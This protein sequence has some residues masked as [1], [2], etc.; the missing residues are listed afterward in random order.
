MNKLE[1]IERARNRHGYKYNYVDIPNKVTLKDTIN[2]EYKGSIYPQRVSKHL[3]GRCPEKI[4][5][6]KTTDDFISESIEIWGNRFDYSL[7]SY[8]NA[9][10]KIKFI[11]K[12]TGRVFEQLPNNH[13][14]GHI[15][16]SIN[17]EEFINMSKL[18]TDY[19]Y[20]YNKCNYVNKTTKV[21]LVCPL[22]GDF[23]TYPHIHLSQGTFCPYCDDSLGD[24]EIISFLNKYKVNFIKQ[25]KFSGF[26][27]PFDFYITSMRI[28][29]EFIGKN[30]YEPIKEFGGI[31]L[32]EKLNRIDL[33]KEQYCEEHY[34]SL[35][36]IK[37][38][39]DIQHVLWENLKNQIRR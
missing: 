8:V 35:I 22:H 9:N 7:T 32:Y 31:E 11:D 30:H 24:K 36:K 3:E 14:Y 5:L 37:Y 28:C 26:D 29:I 33:I 18:I 4:T 39:Q 16:K 19:K 21:T 10:T 23:Y 6:R 1:F 15:N 20:N 13:L 25:H 12:E 34:I 27:Y 2:I 17:N 38:N